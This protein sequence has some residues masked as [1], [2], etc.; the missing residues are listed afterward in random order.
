MLVSEV[1]NKCCWRCCCNN[2]MLF[3]IH[4]MLHCCCWIQRMCGC[5]IWWLLRTHVPQGVSMTM[6]IV[7]RVCIYVY[8]VCTC[9]NIS[10]Y[11]C[12]WMYLYITKGLLFE[13]RLVS[14]C[15][16]KYDVSGRRREYWDRHVYEYYVWYSIG[17]CM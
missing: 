16:Y 1:M 12:V 7:D 13:G 11:V 14:I 4:M 8:L 3:V 2:A 15:M 9:M 17:I 6:Y 10:V 5:M